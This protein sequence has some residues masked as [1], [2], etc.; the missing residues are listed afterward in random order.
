MK[1][2]YKTPKIETVTTYN[3]YFYYTKGKWGKIKQGNGSRQSK[4]EDEEGWKKKGSKAEDGG[5]G[6]VEER[7]TGR[8]KNKN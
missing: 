2:Y 8:E 1:L 4:V 5:E 7:G 6:A 3:G